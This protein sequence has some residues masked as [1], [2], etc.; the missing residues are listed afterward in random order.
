M[1]QRV[2]PR[3]VTFDVTGTLLMTKLEEHYTDIG[4]Q[5]G[6][7][8]DSRRLKQSFKSNFTRLAAEHPLFGRHTG[9]GWENWWRIIVHK[10]FK[11][12]HPFVSQDTLNKVIIML[13]DNTFKK[14]QRNE[15]RDIRDIFSQ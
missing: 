4:R 8:V 15:E 1:I 13:S 3:L 6:L 10:V 7:H 9:L 5:Y 2:R 11:D 14:K 12:Q